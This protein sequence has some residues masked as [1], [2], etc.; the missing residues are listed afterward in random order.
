MSFCVPASR[1]S[2]VFSASERW[3]LSRTLFFFGP[4]ICPRPVSR[5]MLSLSTLVALL[6]STASFVS[7]VS[8]L[9]SLIPLLASSRK[10]SSMFGFC[11]ATWLG[12]PVTKFASSFFFFRIQFRLVLALE[13]IRRVPIRMRALVSCYPPLRALWR[14]KS[15]AHHLLVRVLAKDLTFLPWDLALGSTF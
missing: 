12:Q 15:R 3:W 11:C 1:K 4:R 13:R 10:F 2:F 9:H 5:L 8:S 14:K 7:F 6:Q